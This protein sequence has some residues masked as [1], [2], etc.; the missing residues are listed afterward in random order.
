MELHWRIGGQCAEPRP[1]PLFVMKGKLTAR[2]AKA[3]QRRRQQRGYRDYQMVLVL[4]ARCR[5]CPACKLLRQREWIARARREIALA[6]RAWMFTGTFG[7][8]V[9]AALWTRAR[10]AHPEDFRPAPAHVLPAWL[11]ELAKTDHVTASQIAEASQRARLAAHEN[12]QFAHIVAEVR[13]EIQLYLKRI[14]FESG[15]KLRYL[16]VIER[17]ASG[18]PHVHALIFERGAVPVKER[19]LRVQWAS[20]LGFAKARLV[21]SARS[22]PWYVCKYIT[23]NSYGRMQNSSFFGKK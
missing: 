13:R 3:A 7:P 10:E 11:V 22:A 12:R 14:R 15:A 9:I 4:M 8:L 17:H 19:C 1:L 16:F 23:K 18:E 21:T 5:K 20:R 6:S 2:G